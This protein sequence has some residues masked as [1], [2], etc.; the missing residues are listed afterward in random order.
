MNARIECQFES[1]DEDSIRLN[2]VEMLFA[3]AIAQVAIAAADIFD[4]EQYDGRTA[5]AISHQFLGLIMIATSW[6]GWRTSPSPGMAA[7]LETIFSRE[8]IYLLIDVLLVVLYFILVRDCEV[9]T[10]AGKTQ[11]TSASAVSESVWILAIFCVFA[12]W[13]AF[14]DVFAKGAMCEEVGKSRSW[15]FPKLLIASMACSLLCVGLTLVVQLFAHRATSAAEV[16]LLDISL[17]SLVLLFRLLKAPVENWLGERLYLRR[18]KAFSEHRVDS[19]VH[20][21]AR[22]VIIFVFFASIAFVATFH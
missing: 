13:D 6:V 11:L 7:K 18:C 22:G 12:I 16:V 3:L 5:A 17:I 20:Q 9:E 15:L 1:K 8:F 2:F 4:A 14:S 21:V 10:I 19:E